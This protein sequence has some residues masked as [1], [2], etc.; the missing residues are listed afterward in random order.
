MAGAPRVSG[1]VELVKRFKRIL[2][3]GAGG[4]GDAVG[5][6]H[7]Y[8]KIKSLGGE[9]VLGSI[10]WERFAID[11]EPGPI[12][13]ES[14]VGARILGE[15]L[16]VVTGESYAIRSGR[17][18]RPQIVRVAGA[19]GVEALAIDVSKGSEGIRRA[20]DDAAE[21]LGVEAAI[22]VDVGG[23]ILGRGCED[24]LWSPLADSLTLSG[25]L[26]SSIPVVLAVHAPG[27]D[28]ELD[29]SL[30]LEYISR[31]ASEGGLLGVTGLENSDMKLLDRVMG[32]VVSE[33]SRIPYRA[34]RGLHGEISI[35]S[36]TRRVYVSPL[37][38]VTYM[39]DPAVVYR[40]NMLAPLVDGTRNT[41]EA[42]R[43]LNERC[44]YTELNLE[45]DIASTLR[46]GREAN[47]VEL[48]LRGRERLRASGCKPLEC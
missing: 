19:L 18:I 44:I 22:A 47:P 1:L 6:L 42:N 41:W 45:E 36:G 39:L 43:I 5:A 7:I 37:H 14:L 15:S 46:E 20:L 9:P 23:D 31:I 28:G 30:V 3:F 10:V 4:G 40:Y 29:A 32:E 13:V 16:A 33:A 21:I 27:A 8:N 38:I 12:P 48:K 11:P 17:R 26:R 2:V 25:S 34:Y 35:R 24:E